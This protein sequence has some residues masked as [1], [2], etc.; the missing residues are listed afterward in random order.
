MTEYVQRGFYGASEIADAAKLAFESDPRVLGML[1]PSGA[2]ARRVDVQG[3]EAMFAIVYL[4][5]EEIVTPGGLREADPTIVGGLA[6]S[7]F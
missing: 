3:A 7:T 1:P 5:T 6:G 4:S 2:P